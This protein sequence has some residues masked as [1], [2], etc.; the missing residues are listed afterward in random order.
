MLAI[1]FRERNLRTVE[2]DRLFDAFV[3]AVLHGVVARQ[4]APAAGARPP[5]RR[6]PTKRTAR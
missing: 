3:G 1:D 6:A 5:K 4:G 2:P